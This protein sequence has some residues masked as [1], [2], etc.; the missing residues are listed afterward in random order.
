MAELVTNQQISQMLAG[1]DPSQVAPAA[2]APTSPQ[3]F[4][5]LPPPPPT[6]SFFGRS[7]RTSPLAEQERYRNMVMEQEAERQAAELVNRLTEI[8][9]ADPE[10]PRQRLN[11]LTALPLSQRSETGKTVLGAWDKEADRFHKDLSSDKSGDLLASLAEAGATDTELDL[12]R[13]PSGRVNSIKARRM[14][15]ELKRLQD[16][17]KKVEKTKEE[18]LGS[19][20]RDLEER[21]KFNEDRLMA[22]EQATKLLDKQKERL[23]QLQAERFGI[24]LT[25][26]PAA[27]P[28]ATGGPPPTPGGNFFAPSV[29][30]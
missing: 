25:G 15:G 17:G 1:Y 21:I 9:P 20:I 7:S 4:F 19:E 16:A 13:D 8:D 28:I 24:P 26:A 11:L 18:I 5:N 29:S 3:A 23:L 6:T 2:Q 14:L 30:R 12:V 22:D 27:A 10:A